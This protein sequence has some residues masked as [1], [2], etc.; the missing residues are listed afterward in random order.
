M[1]LIGNWGK[2]FLIVGDGRNG[3]GRGGRG[4]GVIEKKESGGVFFE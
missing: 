3:G 4:R 1:R 2:V